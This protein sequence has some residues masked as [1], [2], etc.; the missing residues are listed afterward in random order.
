MFVFDTYVEHLC[1]WW[2]FMF[3]LAIY[4][5]VGYLCLWWYLWC[6]YVMYMWYLLFVWM[7]YK[8][9][10]KKVHTGHFAEC[11]TRQR[12]ALPS[13]KAITLGKEPRPG[14]RYRFFAECNA[15]KHLGPW[16][17]LVIND[18]LMLYVTNVCFAETNGKLGRITG[19]STATVKTIPQIRT[20]S[21]G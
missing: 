12:G 17:V 13:V 8:K 1:L 3:V 6:I 18:N 21:D 2:I 20:R 19:R 11:N 10:I 5:C 7:E 16:L 9:Q 4:V 15:W 14:H